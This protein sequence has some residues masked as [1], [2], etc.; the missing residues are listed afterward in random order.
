MSSAAGPMPQFDTP[1]SPLPAR[2]RDKDCAVQ[3]IVM[4]TTV[5]GDSH[6]AGR[7]QQQKPAQQRLVVIVSRFSRLQSC[8]LAPCRQA[9][10]RSC[11]AIPRFCREREIGVSREELQQGQ[12]CFSPIGR[13]LENRDGRAN[14]D[15]ETRHDGKSGVD[16]HSERH[17][18]GWFPVAARLRRTRGGGVRWRGRLSKIAATDST[19]L[20]A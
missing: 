4:I 12:R 7:P 13:R 17:H 18:Q 8:Q 19:R 11:S 20:E 2:A 15:G 10:C 1:S 9:T 14:V 6:H 16:A 5:D 3:S